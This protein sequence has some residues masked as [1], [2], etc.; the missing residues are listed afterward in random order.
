MLEAYLKEYI[1]YLKI[2]KNLAKNTITSYERDLNDY[3]DFIKK[4]YEIKDYNKISQ[5][6]IKNY[7]KS[8]TRK[9][10]KATSITRKLSSIHSFHKYLSNEDLVDR[11][12]SEKIK[13]PKTKKSLPTVLNIQE[14]NAIINL[15]YKTDETLDLRNRA[16]LELAYGSGLRVSELLDLNIADLH[17]NKGLVTVFGKG[18]KERIV[19][20]G[21][22]TIQAL[23]DYIIN[24]RPILDPK[25]QNTL[26]V[27]KFGN[28][29]SRIGFYKIVQ[30]LAD[31][32]SINKKISPHTFR[33]T[34][35]T[36]L[37]ENGANLRSVQELLGHEDIMTTENYTHVSK[38]H[39]K[40]IY[41]K[42]HPRADG[43]EE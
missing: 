21:E 25:S 34:F 31:K 9:D 22:N 15:T 3:L 8:L 27:N 40:N 42:A 28:K 30:N 4:N 35:A 17:L 41:N 1:Y 38:A 16:L 7:V 43:K 10:I 33:H 18:S 14:I 26:F 24:A 32:A 29:L 23:K 2:T 12:V 5:E 36:H 11:D 37:L 13:K 6:H 19:P 39:L 20:L